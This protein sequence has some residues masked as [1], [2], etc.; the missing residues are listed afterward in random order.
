MGILEFGFISIETILVS[1][2][3]DSFI[4]GFSCSVKDVLIVF[5]RRVALVVAY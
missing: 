5:V 3:G 1:L 2:H 4:P